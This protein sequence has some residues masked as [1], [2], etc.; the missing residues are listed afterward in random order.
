MRSVMDAP[1]QRGSYRGREQRDGKGIE[2]GAA[3][4]RGLRARAQPCGNQ[5]ATPSPIGAGTVFTIRVKSAS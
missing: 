4:A 5:T 1:C 3:V 2:D